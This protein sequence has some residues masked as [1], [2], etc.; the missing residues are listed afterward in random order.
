[1]LSVLIE[2]RNDEEGLARTLAS[3]IGGAVEGV[4]R[5]VIVCD[6][7]STDQTHRVAEHAGCHL[8]AG[9]IATG[10]GQA[11]GD[12]LLLLEPGARLAE[13]WIDEVVAHTAKQTMPARFSRARGN[14]TPFL[15]RV[16]S[17][18]RALEEGL[19][20]SKRQATVLAKSARSAEALARGLA[21]RR[22]I[23]EIWVAPPK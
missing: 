22:L 17:G 1:M 12:W 9:G 18:N 13:G 2:T 15:V 6:T 5:D 7:G 19:V 8:V 10:I 23:A 16:F 14:R 4:V 3:L 21:T 20:I 11:K